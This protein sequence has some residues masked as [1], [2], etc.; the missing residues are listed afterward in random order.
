MEHEG[1]T[2][3]D[4]ARERDRAHVERFCPVWALVAA[5]TVTHVRVHQ[6]SGSWVEGGVRTGSASF[7][8]H[9]SDPPA[10]VITDLRIASDGQRRPELETLRPASLVSD[11]LLDVRYPENFA[12]YASSDWDRWITKVNAEADE[13]M[14][15]AARWTPTRVKVDDD[16]CEGMRTTVDPNFVAATFVLA[17]GQLDVGIERL[18]TGATLEI[19][20]LRIVRS[21][22]LDRVDWEFQPSEDEDE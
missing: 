13:W 12:D 21:T 18:G 11:R 6:L 19:E 7:V 1:R 4:R 9:T 5:P 14:V 15:D 16:A 10:S 22:N 3:L 8:Q 2:D 20:Q 17:E